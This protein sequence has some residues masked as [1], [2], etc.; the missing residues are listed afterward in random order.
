MMDGRKDEFF[1]AIN[2]ALACMEFTGILDQEKLVLLQVSERPGRINSIRQ[3]RKVVHVC[4]QLAARYS[5][6]VIT[7]LLGF[8][9]Y[10][11]APIK[12]IK[13]PRTP[14]TKQRQN[15]LDSSRV[16]FPACNKYFFLAP[17]YFFVFVSFSFQVHEAGSLYFYGRAFNLLDTTRFYLPQ[18]Y[19]STD[20]N[21]AN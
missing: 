20:R 6:L 17:L 21:D 14:K 16:L 4:F 10:A 18:R 2:A 1:C 15:Y 9:L 11:N 19:L 7:S 5:L 8:F 12:V 3:N 13:F